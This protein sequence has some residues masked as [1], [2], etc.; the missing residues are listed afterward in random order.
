MAQHDIY[1]DVTPQNTLRPLRTPKVS[2]MRTA[3]ATFS[4]TSY[5]AERLNDMTRND[6]FSACKIHGLTAVN[7]L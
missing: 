6:M 4:A 3:L 5:T 1:N 2:T 7:P